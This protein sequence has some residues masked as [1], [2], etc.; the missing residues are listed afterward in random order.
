VVAEIR[1]KKIDPR[2]R[3]RL[4][5]IGAVF[6]SSVVGASVLFWSGWRSDRLT[7]NGTL[8][9]PAHEVA[10][11]D[12]AV[13]DG[14]PMRFSALRGHWLLLYVGS[15]ECKSDCERALY[16][17]R[18]S[19]AALGR[20]AH[21]VRS[22]MVITD[23]HAFDRLRFQLKEYP[24]VIPLTGSSADIGRLTQEFGVGALNSATSPARIYVVDPS[25]KLMLSYPA[26]AKPDGLYDD[27]KRLLGTGRM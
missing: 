3:L 24:D 27:M 23:R 8:I 16:N 5:L 11:V 17:M 6:A 19:I 21:R 12:V 25:G 9:E 1:V 15:S 26:D 14:K 7:V 13:L 20:H 22:A 10:D 2:G 18:Q 4:V